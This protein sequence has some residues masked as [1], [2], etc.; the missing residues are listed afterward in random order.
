MKLDWLMLQ[1][2]FRYYDKLAGMSGT[3]KV[4]QAEFFDSYG[5]NVV[6]IP[7]HRPPKRVHHQPTI[8]TEPILK[9]EA[10]VYELAKNGVR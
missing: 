2:F 7:T 3:A 6:R 8:F 10:L 5:L 4:E 1:V 9:M